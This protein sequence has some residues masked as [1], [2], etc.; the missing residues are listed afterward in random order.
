VVEA[1][2]SQT[3]QA[4]NSLADLPIESLMQLEVPVVSSPSKYLQKSTEAPASV[5]VITSDEIQRYGYRTLADVLQSVQGFHVSYDRNYSFVGARGINLG[6]YNSRI[7]LL[8]DGH[9]VNNNLTDGAFVDTAFLLDMDLVDRVEVISGPSAVL[10]GN[11]AFLGVINVIT[12]TGGQLDGFEASG[13]YG[14]FDAYK[15]RLSYGRLFASGLEFLFSGTYYDSA[16]NSALFFKEFDTPAQNS[17]VAKN[18]DA[19]RSVSLFS[20]WT[21]LDFSLE[22]A[23]NHREKVNPTAQYNLTTFDDPRLRTTDEQ[24]YAALKYM[25]SFLD[26]YDVTARLYLDHYTHNIGYPQML[27]ENGQILYSAFS[28]EQDTGQWWGTEVQ[29]NHCL[30]GRHVFTLGAEYRDDFRQEARVVNQTDPA[31]NSFNSA[32]RQSY[33]VYGQ[34][35]LALFNNLHLDGGIRYDQYGHFAP[36][37][38]PRVALIYNPFESSTFKAIYGNAFRAP[39]FTELS[40]ARFQNIMPEEIASYEVVYEQE[41]GRHLRY[42]LT[43]FYNQMDHLIVFD[44]GNYTNFNA[45][46]KGVEMAL[47]GFWTNGFRYRASYSF[48][49]TADHSVTWQMPDSPNHLLKL[50][51]SAPVIPDKLFAGLEFEYTSDRQ[52]LDT[53]TGLGGQPVT[54][55][56]EQAGGFAIVNFTLF[57][58]K[59]LKNLEISASIYNLLDRYYVDPATQF[60]LQNII[61]QDGRSFGVKL[62][63]GF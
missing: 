27:V 41:L 45:E 24:G 8:V 23:F 39:N 35:D 52:T 63:Y 6:D 32:S 18:M 4:A 20:S 42:S 22:G 1:E 7:L 49:K 58:Q 56:G 33:G 62:T 29:V 36:A 30:W 55:Q 2:Q 57:N 13:G 21:Y 17:G 44:S 43:G 51:V 50:N 11:N 54:V 3:S 28:K 14:T 40:D 5:T 16:G 25:H 38:D 59:L 46:T 48:Q 15:A 12:R 26:D 47:A 9:R 10:Y 31:Q 61:P 37:Y 19:D 53:I 34:A 60:H